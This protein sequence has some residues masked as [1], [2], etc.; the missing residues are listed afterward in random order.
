[1]SVINTDK[2]EIIS[3][4]HSSSPPGS[5]RNDEA[6]LIG[7][8]N[9]D[10][11]AKLERDV[12]R[13]PNCT[14]S[15]EAKSDSKYFLCTCSTSA[16][17]FDL[18]CEACAKYCH[19][20]HAPTLEVPG[21]NLCYCGLNNHIIT[22]EMRE[23][24]AQKQKGNE[25]LSVCF[26]SKF[27]K[28][29]PNKGFFRFNEK[30]YCSVCI[31]Y[32]LKVRPF[33][34]PP[35]FLD[36]DI[37]NEYQCECTKNHEIN[38]IQLNADFISKKNFFKH[39]R[40]INFNL[41]LR[42]PKSKEIYIDT[43]VQEINNYLIKKD[44]ESNF[45]FFN[46][47]IVNKSLELFSMFSVYWENKF[48]YIL[49]SILNQYNVLDLFNILSFG[50]NINRLDES[51][52]IN[53]ISAKFYFAEL[54]FDYIIR[55]YTNTY[56]NLFNVKTILNMD[57]YQ[58]LIYIHQLKVFHFYSKNPMENNYLDELSLNVVDL[59]DNILKIN[60]RFPSLF[61]R[62]ISYVFPT[63]NRIIKY[64]IKYNIITEETKEKYFSLV[65][66]T[67]QI[68]HEKKL[69]N[70]RDSCFYILKSILYTILYNNDLI[71]YDYIQNKDTY[72][73]KG[74]MFE[75]SD[76]SISL[77]KI[78]LS[79]IEDY[80]RAS[81]P[82]NDIIFDYYIQKTFELLL[83]KN[84]FYLNGVKNLDKY[85]I[86]YIANCPL[87]NITNATQEDI[88]IIEKEI[89]K[90]KNCM[91]KRYYDL[92]SK[93]C[94]DMSKLNRHYFE[95]DIEQ[96]KYFDVVNSILT[97]F[98]NEIQKEN[99]NMEEIKTSFCCFQTPNSAYNE[100]LNKFKNAVFFSTFFQR[101]E[102]F[103]HIYASSKK[104][105]FDREKEY[106]QESLKDNLR[107]L[108]KLLFVL[109]IRDH[110]F[111]ILIM[112]IKP[113]IFATTFNDVYDTLEEFLKRIIEM[114]YSPNLQIR[115][116]SHL[117][118]MSNQEITKINSS[119]SSM[120][121]EFILSQSESSSEEEGVEEKFYLYENFF[122]IS[123]VIIE[124]I[125]LNQD[126]YQT[127][128]DLVLL[129]RKLFKKITI[130]NSE[131]LN[132]IEAFV[133]IFK[134]IFKDE[135]KM[136]EII[137]YLDDLLK[138]DRKEN[139][140]L[141]YFIYC[142][143]EFMSELYSSDGHF[144]NYAKQAEIL[145]EKK[146]SELFLKILDKR[147]YNIP[148]EVEYGMC[149]YFLAIKNPL[150]F[151]FSTISIQMKNLYMKGIKD[152]I[153][154]LHLSRKLSQD[155][156][157]I[158][159]IEVLDLVRK[160]TLIY[161]LF[162]K[163]RLKSYYNPKDLRFMFKYFENIILRP[164]FSAF[165]IYIIDIEQARGKD[166]F[167]FYTAVFYFLK[168]CF[169]FYKLPKFETKSKVSDKVIY[170]FE[171]FVIKHE[172]TNSVLEDIY[173]SAKNFSDNNI[174]YFETERIYN[175]FIEN[176]QRIIKFTLKNEITSI[177]NTSYVSENVLLNKL[178]RLNPYIA[179][180]ER[181]KMIYEDLK[182][183]KYDDNLSLIKSYKTI[184]EELEYD[185]AI[186]I[187]NYLIEKLFDPLT[188][189][190]KKLIEIDEYERLVKEKDKTDLYKFFKFQ[191]AYILIYLNCFFYNASEEFQKAFSSPEVS[192]PQKFYDFLITNIILAINLNEIK[193]IYDLDILEEDQVEPR[194]IGRKESLAFSTGRFAI[195]FIQNL[196]EGHNREY[197]NKF[198]NFEFDPD[199][200]LKD[201]KN[202]YEVKK[203][204]KS[205]YNKLVRLSKTNIY[206]QLEAEEIEKIRKTS[207]KNNSLKDILLKNLGEIKEKSE[208]KE[209]TISDPLGKETIETVLSDKTI[210]VEQ[211]EKEEKE[212][213]EI[214]QSLENTQVSFFNL[215]S[216][217]QAMINKNFHAG[218][219]LDCILFQKVIK[220]KNIEN[221]SELY[222]RLSDLII[223]MIQGTD[224][225]NFK[226]F[227]S[228][229]LPKS[230]QYFSEEGLYTPKKEHRIFIFL[231]LSN[232]IKKILFNKNLT[233][234]PLCY[235]M[236]YSL[237]TAINNI[238]S[239][240]GIDLSVVMA[241]S[242]IFP[243]DDLLGVISIYLR[244]IYLSHY[245]RL[246]YNIDDFN[247]EL[248]YLELNN[249]QWFELKQYFR[250]NP[251][252]YNDKYFQLASQ[253]Y[254]FLTIL[255]E[256][257]NEKEAEKVKKYT[258]KETIESK[259][260]DV[261]EISVQSNVE[262]EN[263]INKI[264][265]LINIGSP[266]IKLKRVKPSDH[267]FNNDKIIAAKFFSKIVKK[268]EFRTESDEELQ[269]KIIY[270][271]CDPLYYYI[272]KNNIHTF[273]KYVDRTSAKQ[274]LQSLLENLD[275][276]FFE[277]E[278]KKE[279][280]RKAKYKLFFLQIDYNKINIYNFIISS[281]INILML[282][283]LKDEER[284][285][286]SHKLDY[287][288]N[289][290]IFF[291]I[292][293]NVLYL[294]MFYISKYGFYISLLQ[295]KLGKDH[296][297]TLKEKINLYV[298]DSFLLNDEIYL[299]FFIIITSIFGLLL[300]Y[301][302]FL[303][304]IQ[305]LTII[306]FID[307]IREI[308]SAF[309]LKLVETLEVIEFLAIVI[310]FVANFEFYFLIDEFN[311]EIGDKIEN[312]CQ[313][314]LECTINIFNHGVRSGGG[315]GDLLE[316]KSYDEKGLYFLRFTSDLLFYI[317]VV[318]F[319]L[320]IVNSIIVNTFTQIREDSNQKEED[321][322]NRCF[323][324]NISRIEFQKNKIDIGYHRKYEHN[325]NNY[326]KFFVFLWNI[327]EKDMDADQSFI[328]NC[329]KEK[330]IKFFPMNCAKSIGEVENDEDED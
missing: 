18:I 175:V 285:R 105:T 58:R 326:I 149:R 124:L 190:N 99:F 27:F 298:L 144:F 162:D 161:S 118:S 77:T 176:V 17:G 309:Q 274:K 171:E 177:S 90:T 72:E 254:L 186:P 237:F 16:K 121:N 191:N 146:F 217:M 79:I 330:D 182:E 103:T 310:Y 139:K 126:N 15:N 202:I 169:D 210:S 294:Y 223:E 324:C 257:F 56:C 300:K 26:Y 235:N 277:I 136:E 156:G 199:E 229:G 287:A 327:D 275:A 129:S 133:D 284:G 166:I 64:C 239:Q 266:N 69:G 262:E 204:E 38:I 2:L 250:A 282:I 29:I 291:Q 194:V 308:L 127:L 178:A 325:T 97:E 108:L 234:D 62:I 305:L 40:E 323:I 88:K 66:E 228:S 279:V 189:Y 33:D 100:K 249:I 251:H 114:I 47:I 83:N 84:D 50:D 233:F 4:E 36:N 322:K 152:N 167:V 212:E 104:F 183:K 247:K 216:Y 54:L 286:E 92:I 315:V 264:T 256:K 37:K 236:K 23:M 44:D 174:C 246:N 159:I 163:N 61:E 32:C 278:F 125:R 296:K 31:Q 85:E 128:G 221:L 248:N 220:F 48:W 35:E 193:K 276:F 241:F 123:D 74:F 82:I 192:L 267:N 28:V 138:N 213:K 329:I 19:R 314:L 292:I 319:L 289:S 132:I 9:E 39:L 55:T 157:V 10:F 80:D 106:D 211:V 95:F 113:F 76:E 180:R 273:F 11:L 13:V 24:F 70:L 188:G 98:N 53:F 320:N 268:C 304:A 143:F 3:E 135:K 46:D 115:T 181:L 260:S 218:N 207:N 255:A 307:I 89:I 150:N 185:A 153:N 280:N 293:L 41:I 42:L 116:G 281:L 245:C 96:Q 263:F 14:Y 43:F 87:I 170:G 240:E 67:L 109:F 195:K 321:M 75:I 1:M 137:N 52:V 57:L 209:K 179:K 122:F 244:G 120:N 155:I 141:D 6:D 269:L 232:Q 290:I 302:A 117:G 301:N 196:C 59:Y 253:M 21:A 318:L 230:Y 297:L 224:V 272:S 94:E 227:Y 215:I 197:Q 200:F 142:Y 205:A 68:H 270:F 172:L 81:S 12:I 203:D 265:S 312:F 311:I 226:K 111:L 71:C 131:Y 243:P 151:N 91:E 147:F 101:L 317:V 51:M 49:P 165:N 259:V 20:K 112:N 22:P 198:F 130:N 173:N 252:I 45:V 222:S 295:N 288:I 184:G 313:N 110:K 73:K 242:S 168:I 316:V 34:A 261:R 158:K 208:K 306:K 219:T 231:E 258:E 140:R 102:E 238:L 283:F 299:I 187:L 65:F 8:E 25:N 328:N 134:K 86:E 107:K 160:I 206:Q 78:L 5:P 214:K 164:L 63:F 303:F 60:E 201:N 145:P 271:I 225:E 30:I 7:T 148:I 154:I 93:F 119:N